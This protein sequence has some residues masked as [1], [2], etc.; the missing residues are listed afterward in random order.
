[1]RNKVVFTFSEHDFRFIFSSSINLVP[2]AQ[3]FSL[4]NGARK[5]GEKIP[6]NEVVVVFSVRRKAMRDSSAGRLGLISENN[7][8]F[9]KFLVYTRIGRKTL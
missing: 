7:F 8:P 1:M 5:R 6:G 9:E 4:L 2:R 3:G